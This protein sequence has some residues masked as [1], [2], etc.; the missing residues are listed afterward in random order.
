[1]VREGLLSATF[2]QVFRDEVSR[3]EQKDRGCVIGSVHSSCHRVLAFASRSLHR[4]HPASKCHRKVLH[5]ALGEGEFEQGGGRHSADVWAC[6]PLGPNNLSAYRELCW[7]QV[8][9]MYTVFPL[10]S[11]DMCPLPA[12]CRWPGGWQRGRSATPAARCCWCLQCVMCTSSLCSP[13]HPSRWR[14][15]LGSACARCRTHVPLS[16]RG[17]WWRRVAR[18]C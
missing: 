15:G 3:E 1:M 14:E 13:S 11:A 10:H 9:A 8:G 12:L 5:A 7:C 17:W 4:P 18:M 2:D 16:A 6:T